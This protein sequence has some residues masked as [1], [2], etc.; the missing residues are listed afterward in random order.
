MIGDNKNVRK[1]YQENK[2]RNPYFKHK[3][4]K[5]GFN[6]SRYIKI[7]SI[8]LFLYIIV[9]SNLLNTGEIEIT[10]LEMIEPAEINNLVSDHIHSLKWY[11]FPRRNILF[12][13]RKKLSK[14]INNQYNLEELIIE[15]DRQ[16]VL[17]SLKEKVSHVIIYNNHSQQFFFSDIDGYLTSE[18]PNDRV[19]EYWERFPIFNI[20]QES[21]ATGDQSLKG[22]TISFVLET[23]RLLK[24]SIVNVQGFE[25]GETNEIILV[26]KEGWRA[27]FDIKSEIKTSVD[28]LILII[29]EKIPDQNNLEYIDLRLGN[30]VFYK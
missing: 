16:E 13:D 9:Y 10:G 15:I 14:K 19:R 20:S 28:N 18:I 12:A 17:I 22:E 25:A 5:T 11:L 26:A 3:T 24:N 30:K 7:I 21:I 2:F 27:F 6:T 23:N 1:D 8:L 29:N 4:D